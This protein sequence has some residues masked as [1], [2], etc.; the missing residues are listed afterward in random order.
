MNFFVNQAMG[1]GNSGV[2]HA[3]FYRAKRFKEAGI[4]FR[5]VFIY[6]IP[7]LHQAM[8]KWGLKN[9]DVINMWEYFVLGQDY[10]KTGLKRR[11]PARKE[12]S[13]TDR[14]NTLRL[15]HIYTDS[16]LHIVYHYVKEKNKQK[17][18]SKILLVRAFRTEIFN[19]KT[20][21]LKVTYETVDS[22]HEE[23][24]IQNIHLF[25]E[26]GQHLYFANLVLLHRYFLAT[27]DQFFGGNSN[28]IIDRGDYIDEALFPKKIPH[29]KSIGIIHADHLSDRDDPKHPFWNNNYE[30]LFNHIRDF[31]RVVVATEL[32]RKDILIDFPNEKER[33]VTI[34]VG[35]IKPKPAFLNKTKK[36]SKLNLITA[37]RL[38][39]EKHIDL[40][41]KA[42]IQLHDEGFKIKFDIYGQGEKKDSLVDLI[43][44]NNAGNYIHLKGLSD[45]LDRIYPKYDAFIS[46]SFSEGFG[47]TYIEALNATLPVITFKARF[48]AM[49]L[50]RDGEN[51]FLQEF[52]R[53]NDQFNV[54]QL[55]LGI[56]KLLNADYGKL[57]EKT[58]IGMSR[59]SDRNIANDW[60]K[61][62][63][64]L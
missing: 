12:V 52:K 48:G 58:Q 25:D 35:G 56:K 22:E 36:L 45:S 38:A 40:A 55:K 46:A 43:K 61:L 2:E 59:F 23:A 4:P 9:I 53:N 19:T 54:D 24:R 11:L 17:P 5:F 63:N 39:A 14:T 1:I 34:P 13:I 8:K 33:I 28:F 18:Q 50:I 15:K 6:L 20:N 41:I 57:R 31:D 47:L 42:V 37:S 60:R 10:L 26:N 3:E 30:F 32:Q 7:E 64:G 16:G 27:L 62:I 44:K 51:G 21:E 29:T 49:E